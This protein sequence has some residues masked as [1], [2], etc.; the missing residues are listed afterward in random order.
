MNAKTR[1]VTASV[2]ILLCLAP[3]IL[4][5]E[6]TA[7]A[8]AP[9]LGE[10]T[11]VGKLIAAIREASDVKTAATNY[12]QARTM[13]KDNPELYDTYMKK[14]LKLGYP[15]IAL[16]PALELRRLQAKNGTAWAVLGYS[17]AKRNRY[18]TAFTSTV[19][20]MELLPDDPG[21]QHNAG[22][23]M[24]WYETL[25]VKPRLPA[26]LKTMLAANS[27]KWLGK[28]KYAEAHNKC[29]SDFT[30]RASRMEKLK[31][32]IRPA[33]KAAREAA[34]DSSEAASRYRRYSRGLVSLDN[35]LRAMQR[36]LESAERN[37][38][39]ATEENRRSYD[40]YISQTRRKIQS[41]ESKFK[42]LKKNRDEYRK[43]AVEKANLLAK[44]KKTLYK[45]KAELVAV[46]KAAPKLSWLPPAVDG[47]ITPEDPNP[48]KFAAQKEATS[49]SRP[50]S[51]SAA[52]VQLK[53]AKLLMQND[54]KQRAMTIMQAIVKK[55]PDSEAA[56]EAADLLKELEKDKPDEL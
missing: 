41:G 22:V 26:D 24:A 56:K 52:G 23:L 12:S 8:T 37:R 1:A 42:S 44:V 34:R 11:A 2:T 45:A 55:Y 50:L 40:S 47:V 20:G 51:T 13:D 49:T 46:E 43:R 19:R 27:Q 14:M 28:A 15:K 7:P 48:P 17:D 35:D 10:G 38:L 31:T 21:I 36:S 30:T 53:T 4:A 32:E 9:I 18:F 6:A 3:A 16:Y 5:E 29:K 39:G 25:R 33:E 54:R